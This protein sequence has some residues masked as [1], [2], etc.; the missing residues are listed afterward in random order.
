MR[1]TV[2]IDDDVLR[3]LKR[4]AHAEKTSLTKL[5]NSLLRGTISRSNGT[6]PRRSYREKTFDM[7]VPKVDLTKALALAG[8]LEDEEIIRKMNLGQ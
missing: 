4:R 1:T 3:A 6:P 5:I 2:R 8:Q 7:G